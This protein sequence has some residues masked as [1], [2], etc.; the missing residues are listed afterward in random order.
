MYTETEMRKTLLN[1]GIANAYKGLE[2]FR[3]FAKAQPDNA[4]HIAW[5][6]LT[7]Y[8]YLEKE[9]LALAI[10]KIVVD[11]AG[12]DK[13]EQLILSNWERLSDGARDNIV[14][15]ALSPAAISTEFGL[16]LFNSSAT[17]VSQ[18]HFILDGFIGGEPR[19]DCYHLVADMIDRIGNY[20]DDKTQQR[21]EAWLNQVRRYY[22]PKAR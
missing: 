19:P 17:Q 1:C 9:S 16:K 4:L 12:R 2:D 3:Q 10:I 8:G 21:L 7:E 6:V 5:A 15:G 20:D 14:I 22:N 13:V 18:R 11:C